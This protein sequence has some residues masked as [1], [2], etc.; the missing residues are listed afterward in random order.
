MSWPLWSWCRRSL[1]NACLG[2]EGCLTKNLKFYRPQKCFSDLPNEATVHVYAS[3]KCMYMYDIVYA[4][5]VFMSKPIRFGLIII[6]QWI[7]L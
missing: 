6:G 4:S 2:R 5:L 1:K 7:A 3:Y